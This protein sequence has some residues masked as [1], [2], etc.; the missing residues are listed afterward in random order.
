[1]LAAELDEGLVGTLHDALAADIDPRARGHLA[2]HHQA[3]AIEFVEMLPGRPVRHQ[4]GIGQQ[5]P[6]RILVR[7]E[8][9]HRL[10]RLDQQRLIGLEQFER[11]DDRLI[12]L[13]IARRLADTAV[14][15]QILR[16]LRY[17]WIEVVHQHAQRRFGQP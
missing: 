14:D 17:V 11:G 3:L 16:P 6:R 5:H 9:P 7:S 10:A 15:H 8:N 2:E 1:V 12:A 13:P 4:V